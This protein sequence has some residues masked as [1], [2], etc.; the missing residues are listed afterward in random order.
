[1]F[2][3]I[4]RLSLV[5]FSLPFAGGFVLGSIRVPFVQPALGVRY[6]ELLE[7]PIMMVVIWHSAQFISRQ[8]E[9]AWK[10]RAAFITPILIGVLAFVWL[11]L[12]EITIT[13]I[14]NGGWWNAVHI[15]VTGRDPV[16]GPVYGMTLLAYAL[17]PWYI[18]YRQAQD[19][20][21][22]QGEISIQ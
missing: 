18:W 3:E 2:P 9:G 5:Y 19:K 21:R 17:M 16:A 4:V 15:Y 10:G 11:M 13:A 22:A 6:A 14:L 12:V 7:A 8:M 1:M 20:D